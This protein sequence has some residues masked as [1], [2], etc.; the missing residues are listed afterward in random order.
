MHAPGRALTA[1]AS[2]AREQGFDQETGEPKTAIEMESWPYHDL[3]LK[4]SFSSKHSRRCA[5]GPAAAQLLFAAQRGGHRAEA[6]PQS[7]GVS[8]LWV[9]G[10]CAMLRSQ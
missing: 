5:P 1:P 4:K 6:A 8:T 10:C 3:L 9:M 7:P 2:A